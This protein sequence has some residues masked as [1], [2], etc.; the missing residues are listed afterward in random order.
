MKQNKIINQIIEFEFIKKFVYFGIWSD[1][2]YWKF[3]DFM[4]NL[5]NKFSAQNPPREVLAAVVYIFKILK[6]PYITEILTTKNIISDE[7]GEE[8][9]IIDRFDRI[10]D[11]CMAIFDRESYSDMNRYDLFAYSPR[12][13][14]YV[15]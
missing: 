8:I 11:L 14:G 10:R 9:D 2:D 15:R 13:C 3:D 6:T 5:Y 1:E 12:G 7:N 4:L